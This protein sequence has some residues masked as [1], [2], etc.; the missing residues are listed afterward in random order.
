MYL[1]LAQALL[2]S[3][4][5]LSINQQ[6]V[7]ARST[8]SST[9]GGNLPAGFQNLFNL[10]PSQLAQALTQLEGQNNAG[11]AQQAGYQLMNEFLLL[12]L[13][14]FDTDRAGF[15]GA[16]LAPAVVRTLRARGG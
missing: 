12:M 4:P 15:G 6:N 13:N 5:N 16:G 8:P 3:V 1:T 10:S 2:P 11:G 7:W 14:P 9:P